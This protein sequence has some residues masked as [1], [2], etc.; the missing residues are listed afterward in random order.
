MVRVRE[1]S[2]TT[3][4]TIDI[5]SISKKIKKKKTKREILLWHSKIRGHETTPFSSDNIYHTHK[6]A[7][8]HSNKLYYM[9]SFRKGQELKSPIM[10][11]GIVYQLLNI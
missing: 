9:F 5:N 10:C 2:T 7:N 8:T 1:S 4:T 3:I 11:N 6:Q